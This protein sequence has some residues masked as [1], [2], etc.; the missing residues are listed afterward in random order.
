MV[1]LT[2]I[3]RGKWLV[4]PA[5]EVVSRDFNG[6]IGV[7]LVSWTSSHQRRR[8][9]RHPSGSPILSMRMWTIGQKEP[10]LRQDQVGRQKAQLGQ[11]IFRLD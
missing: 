5:L 8:R 6:I 2:E 11:Q 10:L 3:I 7:P 4:V 9:G 1:Q